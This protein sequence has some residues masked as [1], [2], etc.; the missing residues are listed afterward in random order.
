MC[1]AAKKLG[2]DFVGSAISAGESFD[3]LQKIGGQGDVLVGSF[4]AH[5][6]VLG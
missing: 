6:C 5:G 4:G 2:H 1:R 3:S